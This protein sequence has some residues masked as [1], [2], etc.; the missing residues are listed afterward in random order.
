MSDEF[1]CEQ[2]YRNLFDASLRKDGLAIDSLL[3][4][5]Y[6]L[7]HMTGMRQGKFTYIES[8]CNSTLN[9]YSAEHDSIDVTIAPGGRK[10][11]IVGR[12]RVDAAVFGG[13]RHTWRLQQNMQAVKRD[14]VW[15]LVKS[16]ASTY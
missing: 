2:L 6:E 5:D 7:T 11:T 8:V 16:R 15:L 3:A 9:Y 13:E 1:A 12:T 4:G 14:G 10:A